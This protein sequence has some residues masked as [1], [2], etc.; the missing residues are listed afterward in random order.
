MSDP[1]QQKPI[2]K[3]RKGVLTNSNEIQ[4]PVSFGLVYYNG[5]RYMLE[6]FFDNDFSFI[7]YYVKNRDTFLNEYEFEGETEEN[8]EFKASRLSYTSGGRGENKAVLICI[9]HLYVEKEPM[10]Y[11]EG[12]EPKDEGP[13]FIHYITLEGLKMEFS[14]RSE[15]SVHREGKKVVYHEN[16]KRLY[17]HSVVI[18]NVDGTAYKTLWYKSSENT[19]LMV[20]EFLSREDNYMAMPYSVFTE[21]K[22]DFINLISFLNGAIVMIRGEYTGSFSYKPQIDA[23]IKYLYSYPKVVHRRHNKFIPLDDYHNQEENILNRVFHGHFNKYREVNQRLDLN[24]IIFY[25]CNAEQAA[26]MGERIFIQTIIL[27]RLSEAY[28]KQLDT[29]ENYILS[30]ERYNTLSEELKKTLSDNK[31]LFDDDNSFLKVKSR[32]LNFN[33]VKRAQTTEKM[34]LLLESVNIETTPEIEHI[35]N[36]AR[37]DIIH[38]G[39]IGDGDK[40]MENYIH[41]DALIREVVLKLIE[42][43]SLTKV[44]ESSG[45]TIKL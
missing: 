16:S 38:R 23:H 3:L 14:N 18:F 4:L 13:D 41:L 20:V 27:E 40:A 1:E 17:D 6:L 9:G 10:V 37:H 15:I 22:D 25:L 2:F 43:R 21:I 32:I 5:G 35:L 26:S 29:K 33:Y 31:D 44:V 39:D 12:M 45:A 24:T 11:P 36:I 28:V 7:K 8:Y 34:K 42:Y 30:E 19:D